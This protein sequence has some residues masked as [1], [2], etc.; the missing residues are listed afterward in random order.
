[1]TFGIQA[2]TALEKFDDLFTGNPVDI[3]KNLSDLLP[4]AEALADKSIYLQILSQVALAQAMQK[5]FEIAHGT[6]DHAEGLLTPDYTLARIRILLERGRVFHQADDIDAALPLFE[7][8][9]KLSAEH[10]F[11]GNTIN[12]AHMIAIVVQETNDK[13]A[14]NQK[15]I[16]LAKK[17][18]NPKAFSWLGALHNNLAQNYLESQEYQKAYD[19]FEAC[20]K[21]GEVRG[22]SIISRGGKWGMARA[23]RS[24]GD[25]EKALS[26]QKEL[27]QEYELIAE[28]ES[29]P[30]EIITIGRGMVHE[31]LAL[32]YVD[33]AKKY[34]KS[35][36][37]DLS[38]DPW[39]VKLIP[40]RI[41]KMNEIE[42]F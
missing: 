34:A 19:A 21:Y 31:E 32:L 24:L 41:Q 38:R 40:E 35:A 28:N 7:A 37:E 12:A 29:L 27:S 6:L 39:S 8:S 36:H 5:K 2:S 14:W 20:K 23:L 10:G 13:I 33:F 4:Q 16:E 15:A 18:Q 25:I 42:N 9:W 22:D 3:E 30:F 1:M 11:D 17:S 26:I